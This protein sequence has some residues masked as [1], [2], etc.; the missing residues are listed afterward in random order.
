MAD[1]YEKAS[2]MTNSINTNVGALVALENLNATNSALQTTQNRISTGLKVAS[3]TDNGATWA[4]AQNERA[5][6]TALGSVQDSLNRG[7]STVDVAVSAGQTISDLLNQ[8][9]A[10]ALAATDTSATTSDISNYA[11]DFVALRNQIAKIVSTSDFNGINMLKTSGSSVYALASA[12]GSIKVTVSAANFGLGNSG[13]ALATVTAGSTFTTHGT[14]SAVLAAVNTAITAVNAAVA[15]LGTGVNALQSQ[16]S[17]VQSQSDT[18]TTGI[19]NLVDA[20]VAKESANL[21]ALQTKQQLG[22]QA[23]SIANSSHSTLLS[24]FQ[25]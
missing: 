18:L 7:I 9:K 3:A 17:F 12:S 2:P 22:V 10:K 19:G 5:T 16:L 8:M 24:L 1:S 23:L 6:V 20:D 25:G 13:G 11:N 21:T 14:A 15:K 4:V